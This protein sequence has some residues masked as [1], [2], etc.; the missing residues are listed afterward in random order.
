[1]ACI[2]ICGVKRTPPILVCVCHRGDPLKFFC[3]CHGETLLMPSV[4]STAR[5]THI[6][7]CETLERPNPDVSV[8]S[9]WGPCFIKPIWVQP[10]PR[11]R[12]HFAL[13]CGPGGTLLISLCVWLS[14]GE[15]LSHAY[16]P[17]VSSTAPSTTA[18]MLAHCGFTAGITRTSANGETAPQWNQTVQTCLVGLG[19]SHAVL[20]LPRSQF[21]W[22][23]R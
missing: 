15:E 3:V 16:V 8:Y 1:M 2:H 20:S 14:V 7:V 18:W 12:T 6:P 17:F 9:T 4:Y 19:Q 23:Q 13:L 21:S 10:W 11:D 22:A 5:T